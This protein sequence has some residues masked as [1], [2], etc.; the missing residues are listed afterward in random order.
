MRVNLSVRSSYPVIAVLALDVRMIFDVRKNVQAT[1]CT[2]LRESLR[3]RID[4]ATLRAS[5]N[6]CKAVLFS[7]CSHHPS[8]CYVSTAIRLR[9]SKT[10]PYTVHPCY[11][12]QLLAVFPTFGPILQIGG[13]G[14]SVTRHGSTPTLQTRVLN[15]RPQAP[16]ACALS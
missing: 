15:P 13:R 3:N 8:D 10:C 16:E 5:D 2:R 6:P 7:Q 4:A 12:D 9:W 1:P 14:G 11:A